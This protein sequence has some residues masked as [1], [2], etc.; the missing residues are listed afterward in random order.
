VV[1]VSDGSFLRETTQSAAA[2]II[3]SECGTQWIMGSLFVPGIREDYSSYRSEV[4]GLVA[5]SLTL[6]ILAG[7]C[8]Q[9]RHIIIGCDGQSALLAL[10]TKRE[11]MNAKCKHADLLSILVDVWNSSTMKPFTVHV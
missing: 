7:G 11:D 10:C 9:P 1:A 3:E 5:I 6:R 4:T 8:S 2:W